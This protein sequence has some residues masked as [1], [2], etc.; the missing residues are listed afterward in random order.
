MA[1]SRNYRVSLSSAERKS[2]Q[3]FKRKAGSDNKR[4]RFAIILAADEKRHGHA[5]TYAQIAA[6]AG[7][8]IP[9]VVDTLKKFCAEGILAAVTPLR[10]PGSDTARLKV[11]GADEARIIAKA[12][13]APPEGYCR[14]TLK[15]LS[16]EVVLE[17]P[18][19][20]STIG[21]VL[22]NNA[23]HPHL[24]EYWCIPPGEDPE[25]VA[26]MEDIL[27]TYE[28][29]YDPKHPLWC[30]DEK[31]YQLLDEAREPLPMR[32]GDIKKV[33]SEYKRNGTV[34]IFCF[35]KPHTGEIRH[36]VE[37]TRTAVDF[38]E[39]LKYLVDVIE[40]EAEKITLV[41]DNLNT[42]SIAS[43]YKAF[44]PDEAA[45]IRRKLDIHYTPV[46]GSWLDI[47]EI[48]INIM[49]R[50]CLDRRIASI[51]ILRSELECWNNRYNENPSPINWQFTTKDARVKLKHL[52]PDIDKCRNNRDDRRSKKTEQ[53]ESLQ[54]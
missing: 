35:I 53:L 52:Y 47:A 17:E 16:Q 4:V 15:L 26:K 2:I 6:K 21:R 37:E 22:R 13:S 50:E 43:L 19:S 45:R 31:P 30:V 9:T 11:T 7:A 41:M 33:D 36:S 40:P 28:Q 49:T 10:G 39:K 54:E 5:L 46:H 18:V 12:C 32:P 14:W 29:P 8:S 24:D 1:R 42:H 27:D 23:L 48:G 38:A 20:V 44:T 25:F 51:D 34:S 3:H